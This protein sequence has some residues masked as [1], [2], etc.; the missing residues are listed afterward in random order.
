MTS[1]YIG[2][3]QYRFKNRGDNKIQKNV[4][5]YTM[6]LDKQ[7]VIDSIENLWLADRN[8]IAT[9]SKLL[10]YDI[11]IIEI[12][13]KAKVLIEKSSK[14]KST[15]TSKV[16]KQMKMYCYRCGKHTI[17]SY[18]RVDNKY[19]CKQCEFES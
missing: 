18:S 13:G 5:T 14:D 15:K 7:F 11:L 9:H 2:Q 19:T 17:H 12:K 6:S 8:H 1:F 4:K 16:H 3:V 10:S